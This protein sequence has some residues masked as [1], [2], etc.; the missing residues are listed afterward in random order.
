MT[1]ERYKEARQLLKS[2]YNQSYKIATAYVDRITNFPAIKAEDGEAL[3]Q[4]SIMLTSCKNTLKE[5]GYLNK[6]ENPD[7]LQKIIDKLHL[8]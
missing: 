5:I 6:I 3:Q 8:A 2:K 1:P 7:C 4:L